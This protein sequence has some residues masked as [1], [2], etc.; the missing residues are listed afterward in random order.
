MS[1]YIEEQQPVYLDYNATTPL[2]ASVK[3]AI[4]AG[5]EL[6]TNPAS[7]NPIA[8]KAREEIDSARKSLGNL[9]HVNGEEVIFTS[10]G[11]EANNWV[12]NSAL[13]K[14]KSEY[15]GQMP[16]MICSSI[17]HPS[18][19][20]PLR[21]LRDIG[22]IELTTL[23]IDRKSGQ[24]TPSDVLELVTPSTC[25]VTV[26]LANNETGVLQPIADLSD[27]V[28]K[29]ESKHGTTVFLHSDAS[30][31]VGKIDVNIAELKVDAVT[32]A[33]HK[34]YGPRNGALVL[35]SKYTSQI[36][37]WIYGGGQ[38][39]G[40][41]SG[42]ENTPMI[43]GLGAAAAACNLSQTEA[44]LRTIRD[45]FEQ[46]LKECLPDQHVVHFSASPR[47][48]NTSSVAF[49]KYPKPSA[50]LI[51]KC[52]TFYAS[53]G[54]ACHSGSVSST[55]LAC[56]ISKEL[57][58]RTIRFSFGRET[59]RE[60]VCGSSGKRAK[61]NDVSGKTRQFS[62]E[63]DKRGPRGWILIIWYDADETE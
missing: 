32:V 52:K 25:L 40:L 11:T 14:F 63:R 18:I 45:Y 33:G 47:L 59:T 24:I 20:Q 44:H 41:R 49:P 35:R 36:L 23:E 62:D 31:A 54:S 48:P 39:R 26:M 7:G 53:T 50:D 16:H 28:R 30:Q 1:W 55:L 46:Q 43:M 5:L 27:A 42:T 60:D 22:S 19:L 2:E 17:E 51:A 34:F 37:P 57:V 58:E 8:L 3:A 15:Q 38:E 9:L 61:G 4:T 56:G 29:A 12:I 13:E 10:G 6:W 21:H